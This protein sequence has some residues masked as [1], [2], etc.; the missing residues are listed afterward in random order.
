VI[1]AFLLLFLS[2][3]SFSISSYASSNE[4]KD[5]QCVAIIDAGSTGSRLHI[6]AY[7]SD[8]QNYPIHVHELWSKK[9]K[10]G[11]A[12]L[13]PEHGAL[14]AYLS[15]LLS[16]APLT[17]M[18]TYIYA[19]AGMRLLP[20]SKQRLY[21]QAIQQWF[22]TQ[23]NW[24][25]ME[26]KTI[27]GREE[28]I[29]GWLAINYQLGRLT[30]TTQ[31]IKLPLVSVMDMGGASVQATFAIDEG[32]NI[33]SSDKATIDVYGQQVTLFV[34]SFLGLGQTVMAQQ[35]LDVQRCFPVGYQLPNGFSGTGDA[36]AC[37]QEV[38]KLVNGVHGVNQ[39]VQPAL[40]NRPTP[41]WYTIGGAAALA[42]DP[43]FDIE[44]SQFTIQS[45][46]NKA[47][48]N[49]CHQDWNVLSHQS[50]G[51]DYLQS[52]C[53]FSAYYYSLMVDGYGIKPEQT[54]HLMPKDKAADWSLGVVLRQH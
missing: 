42:E 16:N 9:V 35:F 26:A 52:Y 24:Q 46:F 33:A 15:Q 14:D 18:P 20:D 31:Q 27:T 12:T 5:H 10:P 54:I 3:S 21:Y 36:L 11:L 22:N 40:E 41:Q 45:L 30:P 53:L 7:D 23:S 6:Y 49:I 8:L 28:G 48:S 19:T 4:C 51:N 43:L 34:H 50:L 17:D 13:D 1:Y 44:N 37:Q 47:N 32:A 25:L 2:L 39:I 38:S 29:L